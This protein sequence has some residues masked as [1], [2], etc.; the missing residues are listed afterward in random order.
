MHVIV[1]VRVCVLCVNVC[2]CVS[3]CAHSHTAEQ[4]DTVRISFAFWQI[5]F[6]GRRL[7]LGQEYKNA[8][9]TSKPTDIQTDRQPSNQDL[10]P[11]IIWTINACQCVMTTKS[12]A[13]LYTRSGWF[14]R[15]MKYYT[16]AHTEACTHTHT[17]TSTVRWLTHHQYY[18]CYSVISHHCS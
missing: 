7:N 14:S 18:Y 4:N 6:I 2:V 3:V 12:L 9:H 15:C 13:V 5:K 16:H 8:S 17:H 1:S 11:N 10:W